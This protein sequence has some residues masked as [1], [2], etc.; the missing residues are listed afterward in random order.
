MSEDQ[1]YRCTLPFS[2]LNVTARGVTTPCCNYDWRKND[3]WK[4]ADSDYNYF[5]WVSEGLENILNSAPWRELRKK[6]KKN[7][8]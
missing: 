8:P 5:T 4:L 2:H 7:I 3:H 6:S 1:K